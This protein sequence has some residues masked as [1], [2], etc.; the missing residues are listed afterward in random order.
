M[1]EKLKKQFLRFGIPC[2]IISD[3]GPQY[4]S[5]EF[6][7]FVKTWGINHY[8]TLP[9]HS[10]SNGK[11]ESGVKIIKTMIKK[12]LASGGDHYEASLEQ[13]DTPRQYTGLNPSEM[14]FNRKMRTM[15]PFKKPS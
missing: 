14:M 2:Q 9:Y 8:V 3:S 11:A 1:T 7:K 6:E 13:R 15:L 5:T 10:T 4:T 12:C